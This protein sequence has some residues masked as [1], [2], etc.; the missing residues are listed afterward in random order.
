MEY[1]IYDS[2]TYQRF[3]YGFFH[4]KTHT[5]TQKTHIKNFYRMNNQLRKHTFGVFT[6]KYR[7]CLN[8]LLMSVLLLLLLPLLVVV[9]TKNTQKRS[10]LTQFVDIV[11][12]LSYIW[13]I[14]CQLSW[15][16]PELFCIDFWRACVLSI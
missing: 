7:P 3:I 11:L 15:W 12:L 2:K 10:T 16:Q 1:I 9:K 5:L 4:R 6:E 8:C 14:S 13:V